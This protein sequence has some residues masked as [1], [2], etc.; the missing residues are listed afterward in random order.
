MDLENKLNIPYRQ[1]TVMAVIVWYLN[2]QIELGLGV[3]VFNATSN[4]ISDISW[5]SVL[6]VEET[7]VPR[8]KHRPATNR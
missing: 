5:W 8:E 6:L 7:G 4:S 2:L 3:M 1:R